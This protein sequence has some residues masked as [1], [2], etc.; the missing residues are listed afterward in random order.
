MTENHDYNT[1]AQ[2][3]DD[4]HVPLNENFSALDRDVPIWSRD[5]NKDEFTPLAGA[6]FVS[7]DTGMVYEGDGSSWIPI[8]SIRPLGPDLYSQSETPS[9]PTANDV[10]VDQNENAL[11]YFDGSDWVPVG[12]QTDDGDDTDQVTSDVYIPM[13]GVDLTAT[14]AYGSS[15]TIY[16]RNASITSEAAYAGSESLK[17]EFAAGEHRGS[18]TFY[19]MPDNGW[20][21]PDEVYT[22]IYVKFE[23]AWEQADSGTTCKLYWAGANFDAGNGGWGGNTLTGDNGF[24]VR[25]YTRGPSDDGDLTLATYIYHLDQGSQYGSGWD[26]P[27]NAS[28]G[29]WNC[30]DTYVKMNSVSNGSAN[31]DGVAKMWL[32]GTLQDEHTDLR[33]RT[34][35]DMGIAQVGPGTYWG[36]SE[37]APRNNQVYFDEHRISFGQEG[38]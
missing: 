11:K 7:T 29:T 22:R 8:G 9:A 31:Y 35:T 19:D 16:E 6:H 5:A 12:T 34:T 13:D 26:W 3:T 4:W 20:G 32:N 28:I 38:L 2:G 27:D 25:V 1:P 23:D 37:T 30:I 10:W 17:H 33:W 21:E 15:K 18:R 36:G 24:S 14:D